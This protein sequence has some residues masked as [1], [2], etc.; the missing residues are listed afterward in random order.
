MSTPTVAERDSNSIIEAQLDARADTLANVANADVLGYIGPMYEPAD[1]EIKDAL[2]ATARKRR[3]VLVLLETE[4]GFIT[5]AE[6]IA[7]ILRHHYKRVDFA[8]PTFAMS[9]GTVL[10]M[11]GDAIHMDYA[12]TLGPI[13]PQVLKHGSFVPA[14]GYL[15]QY[16]RFVERS[17][18]GDLTTAELAYFVRNFDPAELY[19]YEQERELSVALLVEWLVRYKF[20]NWTRTATNGT[21]V[22]LK[23]RRERA[24]EIA[25]TLGTVSRWHSHSRGIP[26]E[27]LR[28][29]L[30]LLIDDFGEQPD[31][32]N[33]IHDYFRLLQDY[34]VRRG[35]HAF[36]VHR[37][38]QHVGY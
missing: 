18:G 16:D 1:D 20:K 6:R 32:A 3:S 13:D 25:E 11:A 17:R 7:R 33:A 10:A 35:H 12:S 15:E 22:T 4:G 36:V 30:N 24:R 29:D 14:V 31:L 37:K 5:V 27:V 28:R 21:R 8:V 26:M 2:E 38:G 9:A 34:K 19:R 23:M